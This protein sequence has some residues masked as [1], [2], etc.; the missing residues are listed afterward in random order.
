[1]FELPLLLMSKHC[2]RYYTLAAACLHE[3]AIFARAA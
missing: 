3:S 2:V 1:M